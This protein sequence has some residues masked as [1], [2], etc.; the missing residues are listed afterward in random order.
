MYT[1]TQALLY[2]YSFFDILLKKTCLAFLRLNVRKK[3]CNRE[4]EGTAVSKLIAFLTASK[5]DVQYSFAMC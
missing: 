2:S 3:I 5:K 4:K 1:F